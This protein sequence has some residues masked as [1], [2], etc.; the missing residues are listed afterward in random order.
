MQTGTNWRLKEGLTIHIQAVVS[1]PLLPAQCWVGRLAAQ[2]C[3]VVFPFHWDPD[4]A[5]HTESLHVVLLGYHTWRKTEGMRWWKE[6]GQV[7]WQRK[8]SSLILLR[9]HTFGGRREET[10]SKEGGKRG[11][12]FQREQHRGGLKNHR[13]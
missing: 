10:R 8:C 9:H 13:E 6:R 11:A 12:D 7:E 4:G 2:R 3:S 1:N 5:G